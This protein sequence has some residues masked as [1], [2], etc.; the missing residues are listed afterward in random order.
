MFSGA[1]TRPEVLEVHAASSTPSGAL[2]PPA[3]LDRPSGLFS[4]DVS[5]SLLGLPTQLTTPF[6][7][8]HSF[9]TGDGAAQGR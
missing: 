1:L 3:T 7:A 2:V 6:S 5:G 9:V 4:A 8:L